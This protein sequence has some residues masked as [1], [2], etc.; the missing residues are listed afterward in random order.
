MRVYLT[1]A[2]LS[3]RR[4]ITYRSAAT[5]GAITNTAFGFIRAYIL[6]AVWREKPHIGTYDAADAVTYVFLTQGLITPIGVFL[7]STELGPRIRTGEVAVD[8]YRPCDFQLWFLATDLGR[9]VASL[10]L[11]TVPPVLVG[12]LALPTRLPGDPR[13]WL[14]FGCC[15]A[16]ALVISF[17]LR[18]LASLSGF[19]TLDER[20]TTSL[21]MVVSMFFSGMI[22][23]LVVMPGWLGGLARVL[24]WS[25]TLQVPI[26]V[27]LGKTTGGFADAL[28]F[29][30]AWAAAL[31]ALGRAL[32]SA[33]RHRT[34]VQGG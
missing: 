14:E 23:P 8:L 15:C 4:Y 10:L 12:A 22:V 29:Q 11:R 28:V 2:R 1:A 7:G 20:G 25:A 3:F 31:V 24:P 18:Y 13:R 17:S 33:A 34:V 26:D 9:A 30:L 27:L 6:L 5:A 16:V 19:W 21:L 32:T